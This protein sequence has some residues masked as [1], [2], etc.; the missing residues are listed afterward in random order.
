MF[1]P[2]F[3]AIGIKILAGIVIGALAGALLGGVFGAISGYA[4]EGK[5]GIVSGAL[6][7]AVEGL[8][9]GAAL[10]GL[11]GVGMAAGKALGCSSAMTAIFSCSSKLSLGMIA[12]DMT[13]LGYNFQ[14]R[15][16]KD[17][18]TDKR[19]IPSFIG[20]PLS[21]LNEKAHKNPFYNG[22]QTLTFATAAFSGGYVKAAS[23]FIAGTLVA[24]AAGMKAIE[25]IRPGDLVLSAN[26]ETMETG[27]K[28][29]LETYVRKVNKLVHLT[30]NGEKITTTEDHPFYVN[31]QGF[32][33][34]IDLCIG[35]ELVN[36]SGEI[37]KIESIFRESLK[38]DVETVYNF[39]VDDYHT[40]F[41][42]INGILVHNNNYTEDVE[43]GKT[44]L[45]TKKQKGNYCE[46]KM[47]EHYENNNFTRMGDERIGSLDDKIH[48]GI[49]GVYK[50]NDPNG[51]PQYIIGEAKY[52][53]SQLGNQSSGRQMSDSWIMKNLE[54]VVGPEEADTILI[55]GYER[56]LFRVKTTTGSNG[57]LKV[58]T[59]VK[60]N[61]SEGYINNP[62]K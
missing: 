50:N 35:S 32:V 13:S 36:S 18:K 20:A 52:G 11:G 44:T 21:K 62:G 24:T 34:A 47:D 26:A 23:C 33:H 5:E 46:M 38:D 29:V 17:N 59:S 12:F 19:L 48:H 60:K 25:T 40:Y 61:D 39:K 30:V 9:L 49:D 27:Y 7:G 55:E 58:T 15:L 45:D 22:L 37:V 3:Q 28:P 6:Q 14:E 54:K 51:S 2:G 4:Q 41:V 10:G 57:E 42:G 16:I 56:E 53:T 8:G 1:I 43:S 31:G